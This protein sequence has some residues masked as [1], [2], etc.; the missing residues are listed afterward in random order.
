MGGVLVQTFDGK[1]ITMHARDLRKETRAQALRSKKKEPSGQEDR[2]EKAHRKRMATMAAV[3]TVEPWVRTAKDILDALGPLRL[4]SA[5]TQR[6]E[7]EDKRVWASVLQEPSTVIRQ[8]F[9]EAQSRDPKHT[10]RWVVLVD[11]NTHQLRLVK[12]MTKEFRVRVTIVVDF[13]HVTQYVWKA[14][15]VRIRSGGYKA[16]QSR[17]L[18]R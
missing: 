15:R 4:L 1:G 6:P 11:G 8:S 17:V 7:P 9:E 10:K 3:Y 2:S 18:N 5:E 16:Q 13:I 14:A 12:R